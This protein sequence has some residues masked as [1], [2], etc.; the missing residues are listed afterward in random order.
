M[1]VDGAV[2]AVWAYNALSTRAESLLG[3]IDRLAHE[4]LADLAQQAA[5]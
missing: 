4:M 2:P 3:D 5:P 1:A